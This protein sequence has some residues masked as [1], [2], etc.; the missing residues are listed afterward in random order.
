MYMCVVYASIGCAC[1][2]CACVWMCTHMCAVNVYVGIFFM[3][4]MYV[5]YIGKDSQ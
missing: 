1:V 4:I 2:E 3:G 5:I